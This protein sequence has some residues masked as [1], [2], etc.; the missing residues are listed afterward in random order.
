MEKM[1]NPT[2]EYLVLALRDKDKLVRYAA[3]DARGNISN[4]RCVVPLINSL[5]DNDKDV[6]LVTAE[7]LGKLGIRRPAVH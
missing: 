5:R 2:V 6:R 4:L 3:A 7:V 1:G